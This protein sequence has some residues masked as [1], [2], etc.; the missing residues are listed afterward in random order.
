MRR[1]VAWMYGARGGS[2]WKKYRTTLDPV[3]EDR[4]AAG[5]VILM[6]VLIRVHCPVSRGL[7]EDWSRLRAVGERRLHS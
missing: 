3:R 2:V 7:C 5:A 1:A 6:T 4:S